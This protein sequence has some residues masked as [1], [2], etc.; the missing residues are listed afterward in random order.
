MKLSGRTPVFEL[1]IRPMFRCIDVDHMA[2]HSIDLTDYETVKDNAVRIRKWLRSSSPMPTTSTGGPW[3]PE[4][5]ALFE[6]WMEGFH[7]LERPSGG[8]YALRVVGSV[9]E[10][11]CTTTLPH[12]G[13]RCW[14][15]LSAKV[16]ETREYTLVL[17]KV[18]G[19]PQSWP[20]PTTIREY[21][22]ASSPL[23]GVWV[24][25]ATGK[26]FVAAGGD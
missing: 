11:S 22:D 26:R 1:H 21:F 18:G 8:G 3:P 20:T 7:R 9:Y 5:I 15:D 25:D 23:K 14:L 24:R 2:Q 16:G 6:R 4:W 13:A 10:L 17:E 12:F 19:N